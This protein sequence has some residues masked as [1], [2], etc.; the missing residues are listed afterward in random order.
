M[1]YQA[2]CARAP[3]ARL[4]RDRVKRIAKTPSIHLFK[5]G[6]AARRGVSYGSTLGNGY[7]DRKRISSTVNWGGDVR[8][9]CGRV[10]ARVGPPDNTWA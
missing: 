10:V 2:A 6:E 1:R 4:V 8:A 9:G 3:S 5:W 7:R